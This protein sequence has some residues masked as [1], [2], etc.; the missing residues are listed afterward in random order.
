MRGE[1][2]RRRKK[3]ILNI[4]IKVMDNKNSPA[5]PV[6]EN[7]LPFESVSS[8]LSKREIFAMA[9]MQGL[10]SN[11][12]YNCPSRPKDIVTTMNTA[13]AAIH[14]ADALLNELST[15]QP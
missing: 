6:V 3:N 14:Y 7:G 1:G 9:A 8:G 12:D 5:F 13:K 4:L 10:L 2:R 15:T 11:P